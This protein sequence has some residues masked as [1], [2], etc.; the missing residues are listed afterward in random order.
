[1]STLSPAQRALFEARLKKKGLDV[2]NLPS[3]SQTQSIPKRKQLNY[4]PLSY[5]QER[6][7]IIDQMEPGNPSYNIYTAGSFTGFLDIA[8]V[9]KAFNEIVRR[10]EILRTAFVVVDEQPVM[11]ISPE[12]KITLLVEDL[13]SWPEDQRNAEAL[14]R[15]NEHAGRPFDLTQAPLVRFGLLQLADEEYMMYVIMHHIITDR[16]SAV[17]V[18]EEWLTLYK[19]FSQG[20]PSPLPEV[21][22]QF[23]DFAAWQREWLQGENFT[24][25]FSYWKNQLTGAPLVL[26][27]PGDHPRPRVQTFQGA[28]GLTVLPTTLLLTLKALT[29]REGAT[30]FMTMLAAYNLLLY[31]YTNQQD[32][33]IGL[34]MANRDRPEMVKML[35]YL[36]NMVVVRSKFSPQTSFR[37]LLKIVREA[38]VGAFAHQ[39]L[40]LGRLIQE[41][42]PPPDISRNPIF[43][44]SYI[45]LD[46]PDTSPLEELNITAT[47]LDVDNGT[48]RF[49][50]T[51]ALTEKERGLDTLFEYNSDLFEAATIKR[52]LKHLEI[53]LRGVTTDPDQPISQILLLT[54]SEQAQILEW[55]HTK[56]QYTLDK[57]IQ[58]LFEDQVEHTPNAIALIF[59]EQQLTY[60]ELN[61]RA[62]QVAHYLQKLGVRSE[63]LV[64]LC[65]ERSLE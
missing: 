1:I 39:D 53:L 26:E 40:P 32:I 15:V 50:L 13:R 23:A 37:E 5:D 44:V 25:A 17:V 9:E 46:F 10:H 55:G 22:I 64:G 42:K 24:T 3:F 52:M 18:D 63:S 57:C 4:C 61:C 60:R 54:E 14:R 34:A 36:L 62:N 41:L 12:L 27:V 8:I 6:L 56:Q 28:R 51:L 30:M 65:I 33:L 2:A 7:W 20:L 38:C 29:Q 19:A 43:Q 49:D 16:W 58:Q 31:R 47:S 11:V 35:G 45:Y 48:S 21:T 59:N